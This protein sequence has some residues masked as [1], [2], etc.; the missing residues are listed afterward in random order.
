M[1]GRLNR[2]RDESRRLALILMAI[3]LLLLSLALV[4]GG[5]P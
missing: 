1:T 5:W 2:T 4:L 3:G